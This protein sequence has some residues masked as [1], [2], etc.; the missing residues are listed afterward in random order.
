VDHHDCMPSLTSE[1]LRKRQVDG[2]NALIRLAERNPLTGTALDADEETYAVI[3]GRIRSDQL[4]AGNFGRDDSGRL[5]P[6]V[7]PRHVVSGALSS[8]YDVPDVTYTLRGSPVLWLLVLIGVLGLTWRRFDV[9]RD[10]FVLLPFWI[11]GF[12]ARVVPLVLS[13][14]IRPF[15]TTSRQDRV[16][17]R[18]RVVVVVPC[19]NEDPVLLDRALWALARQTRLPQTVHVVDDGSSVDY[20]ELRDYWTSQPCPGVLFQWTTCQENSG[21]KYAQSVAFSVH[22]EADIFVTVDSDTALVQNALEEGLKPFADPRNMSVGGVEENYNKRVNWLTRSVAVRNTY[23]Q[24]TAWGAQSVFG[25]LQVNRGT[26]ALYRAWVIR[27]I[28]PAYINETFLGHRIKL[29]DDAAL[30]LFS[31]GRGRTVQQ[32][33]AFSLPMHPENLSHHI[34][35][36]VRWSRGAVTRNCWRLRYL[37][38]LSYGFWW[39]VLTWYMIVISAIIPVV[40]ALQGALAPHILALAAIIVIGWTYLMGC[41]VLSVRRS[42]ESWMFRLTS[43]LLYPIAIIWAATV[44]RFFRLYGISTFLKQRWTTRQDGAEDLTTAEAR[45]LTPVEWVLEVQ[46]A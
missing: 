28:I 36:W 5:P 3:P 10:S 40:F 26:F 19:Y 38:I 35:Q 41:R 20:N 1:P 29:G 25:D 44:L 42:G 2:L 45:D 8:D 22:P 12:F 15:K 6:A 16:L 46:D 7:A 9:G 24:L 30:T 13:L 33:S 14:F 39:T 18:Y 31:R 27:E 37:P 43:L 23:Y 4:Q 17:A 34:R 32:V 21:K 11:I